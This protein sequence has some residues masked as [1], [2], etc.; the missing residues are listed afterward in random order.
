MAMNNSK[1]DKYLLRSFLKNTG[2]AII[3]ISAIALVIFACYVV[4]IGIGKA[5]TYVFNNFVLTLKTIGYIVLFLIALNLVICFIEN[6]IKEA[7][8]KR[9]ED[10]SEDNV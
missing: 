8:Q 1:F 9:S 5:S 6:V 3:S 2:L 4:Y 7:N 10:S